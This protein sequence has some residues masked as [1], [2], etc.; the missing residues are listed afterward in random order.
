MPV[1]S[2]S[3]SMNNGNENM[4]SDFSPSLPASDFYDTPQPQISIIIPIF[5]Q[6]RYLTDTIQ[7]LL[8]Q[9]YSDW[10]AIL[11]DD[12]ST[13]GS[14]A[15]LNSLTDSRM[16]VIHLPRNVGVARCRNT[17]T[18]HARGRYLT[19]LDADD[20]WKPQKLEHQL[21]FMKESGCA[22]SFTDYEFADSEGQGTG[23][24]TSIPKTLTYREALGNTTIFT[25]TVMMDRNQIPQNLLLMPEIESED[26]ATWWQ[27]LKAG[28]TAFGLQENLTYYRRPRKKGTKKLFDL[29]RSGS[30]SS[31][32][33]KAIQRIWKLYRQQEKLSFFVSICCFFR[34][35]VNAV[36]RRI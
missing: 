31:N 30:M 2:F 21:C 9:T 33:F 4:Y 20:L 36:R 16:R 15:I 8:H 17:G 32:K 14:A 22:F 10:E 35:A 28:Y 34:Y 13:D 25:S 1:L 29:K 23:K 5:N 3:Q 24:V 27:I 11:V 6:E 7:T 12:A 19:F 26:T 18:A